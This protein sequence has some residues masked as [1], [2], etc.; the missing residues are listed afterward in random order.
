M[1][2]NLANILVVDDAPGNLKLLETV[3]IESGYN[4]RMA[5]SGREALET[6][7]EW[8]PDLILLDVAMP[9]MNGY[10]V[11]MELQ[12][13]ENTKDIPVIFISA[14]SQVPEVMMGFRV[15]GVD[16]ISKP[17]HYEEV[18]ARIR[19]H[20]ELRWQIMENRQLRVWE[21]N[22]LE[23]VA[24][25]K[26]EMLKLKDDMLRMVSHDLKNPITSIL[27]GVFML[28]QTLQPEGEPSRYVDM[29]ERG[30][31][32]MQSL[33][34]D[35]LDLARAEEGLELK[36]EPIQ[37]AAYLEHALQEFEFAAENK[38]IEIVFSPPSD[39]VIVHLAAGRFE[40]VI[41]NLVSNAIKYTPNGG[42]VEIWAGVEGSKTLI[43]VRD[44]GLGIPET[45]LP[46]IFERFYRVDRSTHMEQTGSGLGMA[47]VKAVVEQHKG[48][49]W[50]E[51]ELGKGTVFTVS[52]PLQ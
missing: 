24:H 4:V 41:H 10:Q 49:V 13:E 14:H 38:Q 11:C 16:Y 9:E 46:H 48:E 36:T 33:V 17:F 47:I 30:A 1:T 52:L 26:D 51:S 32:K 34:S 43:Q 25:L 12:S 29:I 45:A 27:G 39:D 3:L 28:R 6:I 19:T 40:H 7:P 35:L 18:L 15:G 50:V 42:R 44:T 20:L 5:S 8:E 21:R 37:L 2:E 23:E 31:E 22:Y